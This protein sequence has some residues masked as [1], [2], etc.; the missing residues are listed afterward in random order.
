MLGQVTTKKIHPC[1]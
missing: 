1:L